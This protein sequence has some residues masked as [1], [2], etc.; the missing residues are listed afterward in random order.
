MASRYE[1]FC[2]VVELGNFTRA[3]EQMDYSQSAISQ[4]IKSLEQEVGTV[5]LVRRKD[6][7]ELSA[8]G[9]QFFPYIQSIYAAEESLKQKKLEMQ[10]LENSAIRIGT[11][12]SVSR[13]LLPQL[14]K[15]F[16]E[17]YPGVSFVL[18][19]GDYTGIEKWVQE[20]TV[21]FGFVNWDAV[22]GV[23]GRAL[24]KDEMLAVLPENHPLASWQQVSLKQL[25]EEPF[26][27]LD[28]GEF[29]LPVNAFH[30]MQLEPHIEYKVY[31]DYSILAMIRQGL[32]VS[33]LY[34]LVLD[35]FENGIKALPIVEKPQRTIA[36]VWKNWE[37]MP[38][39]ARKFAEFVFQYSETIV[40]SI[41]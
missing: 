14:M 37:T 18:R 7:I 1:I 38:Y 39:A 4:A 16:K 15:R 17:Q 29:S 35:G 41:L 6:G 20:S 40:K 24:Y 25:S 10:G 27:L 19:Q 23:E 26:I 32:G 2:K 8:D 21:D 34:G 9:W 3:A 28:E 5:L 30:E 13:N 31:D 12:T 33:I 11:F 36:L 22:T